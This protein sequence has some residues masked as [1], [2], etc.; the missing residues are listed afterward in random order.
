MLRMAKVPASPASG[1]ADTAAREGRQAPRRQR[2]IGGD[3]RWNTAVGETCRHE[4]GKT[5]SWD[6]HPCI[7]YIKCAI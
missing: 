2:T 7:S 6:Y 1:A 5:H 4:M 3:L